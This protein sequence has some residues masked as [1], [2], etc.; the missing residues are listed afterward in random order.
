MI[1]PASLSRKPTWAPP[2]VI[3]VDFGISLAEERNFLH[4]IHLSLHAICNFFII[5][6]R[7]K[8]EIFE[9]KPYY[10]TAICWRRY[11]RSLRFF[12]KVL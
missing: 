8:Q 7:S 6:R 11:F 1:S 2:T 12:M 9:V 3:L 4:N 5:L 10:I